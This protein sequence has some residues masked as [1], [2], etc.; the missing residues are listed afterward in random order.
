[1]NII[2][3]LWRIVCENMN[4]SLEI[5][6]AGL[7]VLVACLQIK[8]SMQINEQNLSREKGYFIMEETN[9]RKPK[10]DDYKKFIGLFKLEN[11]LN[12]RLCGNGDVFIQQYLIEINGVVKEHKEL[13]ETF[14]QFIRKRYHLGFYCR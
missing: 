9:I 14:F 11:N 6:I 12:F 4:T 5:I 13:L 10:D 2:K 7:G 8:L 3:F 1:M